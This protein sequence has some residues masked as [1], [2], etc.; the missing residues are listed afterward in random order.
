MSADT[1]APPRTLDEVPGWFPKV[2]QLLFGWFLEWQERAEFPGDLLELGVYL[3]K[4]A[5]LIGRY[6]RAGDT[7]TI[8][9]L[10]DTEAPDD[11]NSKEMRSTYSNLTRDAFERNYRA[12]HDQLPIV[13]AGPTVSV[14]ERVEPNSCR[15]V[16]V[17]ASHLYDHVKG[18]ITTAHRVLRPGGLIV[19]DDYRSEHTPGVAA[20]VW[21]AVAELGLHPVCITPQKL[22]G[23][24]D[25][26]RLLQDELL[27]WLGGRSDC[28][29]EMQDVRGKRLVRVREP[30]PPKPP[31]QVQA[32]LA[33]VKAAFERERDAR[34]SSERQL[35]DLR[36]SVSYRT[37]RALTA[38][39]RA[40]R[41]FLRGRR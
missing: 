28:W 27:D 25:D 18:D 37:G 30:R 35:N 10:F 20:A 14:A 40:I 32:E 12:F 4:S 39:P 33:R 22:Y 19:C 1:A 3:G 21:E 9:D 38:T 29:H 34:E 15:F 5:I 8:C 36:G 31:P 11:A 23:T 13:I 41:R 16:H 2:D 26:P 7:F 6:Q 24:W 17:D